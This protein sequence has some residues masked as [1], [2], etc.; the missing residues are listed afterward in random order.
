MVIHIV[1]CPEN[2]TVEYKCIPKPKSPTKTKT[3]PT[4]SLKTIDSD[5]TVSVTPPKYKKLSR[6]KTLVNTKSV[7]KTVK[8]KRCP[9]GTR[10]NPRTGECEPKHGVLPTMRKTVKK[11]LKLKPLV[12]KTTKRLTL[13]RSDAIIPKDIHEV[14]STTPKAIKD[15]REPYIKELSKGTKSYSPEINKYLVDIITKTKRKDLF[16]CPNPKKQVK[17]KMASGEK[18]KCMGIKS[19]GAQVQMLKFLNRPR[20]PTCITGPRQLH[21]NCWFNTMVMSMF[22][23]DKAYKF[24]KPIRQTMI[25]GVRFDKTQIE[26]KL[27]EPFI[28]LNNAIQASIDC[29][30]NMEVLMDTNIIIKQLYRHLQSYVTPSL[31]HKV[32]NVKKS[33]NPLDYYNRILGY[34]LPKSISRTSFIQG[35]SIGTQSHFNTINP[36]NKALEIIACEIYDD[37]SKNVRIPQEITTKDGVKYVLDSAIIRNTEKHHF[38]SCITVNGEEYIFDGMSFSRITKFGWRRYLTQNR[39]YTFKDVDSSSGKKI[40]FNFK[41]GYSLLFYYKQ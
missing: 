11:S 35:Y 20:D 40:Y 26:S 21:S 9:N 30:T 14:K 7:V 41:Q 29:D 19:N 34:L 28:L 13:K 37:K 18:Y 24:M 10:K 6:P 2:H 27:R 4:V 23:S 5:K 36:E 38:S 3:I 39:R 1:R 31:K 8:R 25:T 32:Y 15:A 22:V 12:K 16:D 17:V 33:G